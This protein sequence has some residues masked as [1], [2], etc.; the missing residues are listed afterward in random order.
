MGDLTSNNLF[1]STD[2]VVEYIRIY[3]NGS[4]VREIE[5]DFENNLYRLAHRSCLDWFDAKQKN[6]ILRYENYKSGY[7]YFAVD[8]MEGCDEG[9]CTPNLLQS[10]FVDIEVKFQKK[11]EEPAILMCFGISPDTLDIDDKGSCRLTRTVQ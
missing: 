2:V 9:R 5:T 6:H 4:L 7:T 11:L 3:V 8:L 1:T 10:G